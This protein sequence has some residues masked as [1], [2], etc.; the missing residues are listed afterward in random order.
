MFCKK[1]GHQ[2]PEDAK[3]CRSCGFAVADVK[4]KTT[5]KVESKPASIEKIRQKPNALQKILLL[6]FLV[7]LIVTLFY[8][9]Y[10]DNGE[11]VYDTLWVDRSNIDWLRVLLQFGL[12]FLVTFILYKY[13]LRYN[14]FEKQQYK[15]IARREL[16]LFFAFVFTIFVCGL[17]LF[18]RNYVN[19]KRDLQLAEKISP[20]KQT[21]Q[22]ISRKKITR[23]EFINVVNDL[24]NL[25]KNYDNRINRFWDSLTLNK[26]KYPWLELRYFYFT[27]TLKKNDPLGLDQA[28]RA[29][30]IANMGINSPLDLKRF[31]E[32]NTL[33]EEDFKKEKET[34]ETIN[35]IT[36]ERTHLTLYENR[37]IRKI[38]LITLALVF[39]ILYLLRPLFY[40]IKELFAEIK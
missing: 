16:Y 22:E 10:K 33:T 40:F 6:N 1:C 34:L 21:I 8:F 19:K 25:E 36:E 29:Q 7:W 38:S 20:L 11:I 3:F 26:E 39:C 31:I 4:E 9:P 17:F 14:T 24:V 12:L 5:L 2:N 30:R 35:K 32:N 15:K 28:L 23:S 13:L 18:G 27:T 37:E